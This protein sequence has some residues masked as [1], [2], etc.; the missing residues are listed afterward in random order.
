[1]YFFYYKLNAPS[2]P[3]SSRSEHPAPELRET[4]QKGD[5]S[6][7]WGRTQVFSAEWWAT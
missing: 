1:M 4:G 6:L 7:Q 3:T 2:Q 5:M